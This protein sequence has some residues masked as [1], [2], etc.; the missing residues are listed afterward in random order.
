MTSDSSRT[1]AAPVG[2][3]ARTA[4]LVAA[5]A[6]PPLLAM[7]GLAAGAWWIFFAAAAA[8]AILLASLADA[9]LAVA[10]GLLLASFVDYNTGRLTLELSIVS[11]WLAWTALVI[12]WRS[13]WTGWVPPPREMLPGLALW[14]GAFALGGVV[15]LFRGHSLRN[16]GLE[17]FAALW[18]A[19]GLV[20]AQ[21]FGR[22]S[23][24]FAGLA[25]VAIGILHTVFGLVMLAVHQQRL[26]G[27]Y[28]TTLTGIVATGLWT[29]S[30][31]APSR[32]VRWL[33]L[34]GMV[35]M[36]L[37]LFFSF[38]RGYWLGFLVGVPIATLLAWRNLGRFEP[39][40]RARRILLL[41]GLALVG[42]VVLGL[43][44]SF[45]GG[46][47][48]LAAAGG[49]FESSFSTD[50]SGE[51]LSNLIR[52]DEY[53]RAIGA[54]MESPVIGRG[55]GFSFVT[56]DL[57]TR[58]IR[59]QW[60]V[61][62]YYLLLWLKL[63]VVGLLAFVGLLASWIAAA[64]R[65]AAREPGWLARVWAIAAVAMTAQVATILLTNYSLADV[66]TA[67]VVAYVWG[68]FWAVRAEPT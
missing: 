18:P 32:R 62:N 2:G 52:L 42:V 36:L 34:A 23:L 50:W 57:L 54:A 1:A 51:T 55:L 24:P 33:C 30:I 5:G 47:R 9:R 14:F 45:F 16:M 63:G 31:L 43:S 19:A 7:A 67:S 65:F 37:H 11:A 4:L 8:G 59:D 17:L 15:G 48:L 40:V 10:I 41:P 20:L 60:F 26:G 38:T 22:R 35:P 53:D 12:L 28:F 58:S 49:R 3:A 6:L 66:T 25:L 29:A 64:R 56:R 46:E 44:A 61:H 27:I 68:V 13:A 21:R 39:G